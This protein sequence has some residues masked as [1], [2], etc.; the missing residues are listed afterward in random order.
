MARGPYN[1]KTIG[2]GV[3]LHADNIETYG[4]HDIRFRVRNVIC[5]ESVLDA[6]PLPE[7]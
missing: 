5:E 1:R 6:S 4:G 2:I 7:A 3:Q